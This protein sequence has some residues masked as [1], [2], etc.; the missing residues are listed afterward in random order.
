MLAWTLWDAVVHED[1]LSSWYIPLLV[2]PLIFPSLH[3]LTAAISTSV[4][5]V[6]HVVLPKRHEV[7]Y[8]TLEDRLQAT[9]KAVEI[10][11][12]FGSKV[13]MLACEVTLI[14]GS[15]LFDLYVVAN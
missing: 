7:A 4:D 14:A 10:F 11:G 5:V 1:S 12:R 9:V 13:T 3:G 15:A 2:A 8:G 6:L